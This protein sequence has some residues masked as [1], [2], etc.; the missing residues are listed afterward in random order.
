LLNKTY[1]YIYMYLY[2]MLKI[3]KRGSQSQIKIVERK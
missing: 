1:I 3:S 2:Y